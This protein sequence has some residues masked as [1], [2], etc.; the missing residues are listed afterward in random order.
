[1]NPPAV[2]MFY[3]WLCPMNLFIPGRETAAL[4]IGCAG[5]FGVSTLICRDLARREIRS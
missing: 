3:P 1:M 4:A 5:A 2:P